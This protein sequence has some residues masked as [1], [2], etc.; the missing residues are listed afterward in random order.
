MQYGVDAEFVVRP[1]DRAER[2]A[3]RGGLFTLVQSFRA[4]QDVLDLAR[5]QAANVVL[6]EV[7]SG[8]G[9]AP[10]ENTDI[11]RLDRPALAGLVFTHR[12]AAGLEKP[13][14]ERSHGGGRAVEDRVGLDLF[15]LIRPWHRQRHNR[16]LVL[17]S[18]RSAGERKVM[19]N[20]AFEGRVDESLN[21]LGGAKAFAEAP[22]RGAGREKPL[23]D[24]EVDAR[25][26]AAE[27]VDRL[28]GIADHEEHFRR[29]SRRE[30]LR[31]DGIGVLEFVDEDT[32]VSGLQLRARALVAEEI[33]GVKQ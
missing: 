4:H 24:I 22:F 2:C 21:R 26:G 29:R 17:W 20:D 9:E 18:G 33:A 32:V 31:L 5:F 6:G 10:E 19:G 23:A 16:G 28:L 3:N 27:A 12:P 25:I 8:I 11:F 7:L 15:A 1:L 13:L 30:D 14:N